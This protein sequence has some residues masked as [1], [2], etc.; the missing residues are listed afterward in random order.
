MTGIGRRA[1][2]I[3]LASLILALVGYFGVWI[4]HKAAA[5][6]ITG[7]ELAE[8]A[9]FLPQPEKREWLYLP[10]AVTFVLLAVQAG[11]SSYPLIRGGVA[12]LLFF[13]LLALL[14][15]YFIVEA[16]LHNLTTRVPLTVPPEYRGQL[17]VLIV[18]SALV[19]A[20][21][22]SSRL[23]CRVRGMM[24]ILLA[25][26]GILPALW[27]FVPLQEHI[28]V[29]YGSGYKASAVGWGPVMCTL[30]FMFFIAGVMVEVRASGE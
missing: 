13:L 11:R 30:G 1:K 12:L 9:R 20:A 3:Q 17:A 10:L 2:Q 25:L 21:P 16:L 18:A 8:W 7:A 23:P 4:P 26:T 14:L 22:W 27:R 6:A 15:P 19:M 29:L 28:A 5:L 24:S